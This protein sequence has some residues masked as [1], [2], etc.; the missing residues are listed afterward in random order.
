MSSCRTMEKQTIRTLP[1]MAVTTA[2]MDNKNLDSK[3]VAQLIVGFARRVNLTSITACLPSPKSVEEP[4]PIFVQ[5]TNISLTL[6]LTWQQC[7]NSS[8][9][10][11]TDGKDGG[12]AHTTYSWSPGA[13]NANSI[14]CNYLFLPPKNATVWTFSSTMPCFSVP[15]GITEHNDQWKTD[16]HS[17]QY[18][19]LLNA[20][21][22]IKHPESNGSDCPNAC[23]GPGFKGAWEKRPLN[24][25]RGPDWI[26]QRNRAPP[27]KEKTTTLGLPNR[28]AM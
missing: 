28:N 14:G 7:N 16:D 13:I 10:W 22:C 4:L 18:T 6:E 12:H 27:V 5:N 11:G 26:A 15:W 1:L 25:T 24:C 20:T 3:V 8:R 17:L 23:Q 21:W 9:A 2:G 19:E